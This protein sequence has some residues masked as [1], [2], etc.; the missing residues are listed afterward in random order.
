MT[1]GNMGVA[2]VTIAER[3]G[4][5]AVAEAA[6]AQIETAHATMAAAK[7]GPNAALYEGQLPRAHA[8]V[9]RLRGG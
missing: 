2:R 9:A 3:T 1:S 8:L 7:H 6:L 4:D 5:L